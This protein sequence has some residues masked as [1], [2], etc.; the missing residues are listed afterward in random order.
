MAPI[1]SRLA[2]GISR[3]ADQGA[4]AEYRGHIPP[5][6][7]GAMSAAPI[8]RPPGSNHEISKGTGT[9][10]MVKESPDGGDTVKT[11]A[12]YPAKSERPRI[13][14][15]RSAGVSAHT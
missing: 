2:E 14:W 12:S 3:A 6:A 4:G 11:M 10:S 5:A 13:P 7:H 9:P 1:R 8:H 15:L